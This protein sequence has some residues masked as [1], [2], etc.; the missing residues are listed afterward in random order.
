MAQVNN[1]PDHRGENNHKQAAEKC[2]D[3]TAEINVCV[4]LLPKRVCVW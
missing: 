2:P 3:T 1:S 4:Q